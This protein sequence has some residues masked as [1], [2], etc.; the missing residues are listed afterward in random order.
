MKAAAKKFKTI[1]VDG[2]QRYYEPAPKGIS[3]ANFKK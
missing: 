3:A 2:K 1:E